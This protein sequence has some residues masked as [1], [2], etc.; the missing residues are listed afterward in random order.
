MTETVFDEAKTTSTSEEP[1]QEENLQAEPVNEEKPNAS[2]EALMKKAS[3][4]DEHIAT[5]TKENAEM[6]EQ[7]AKQKGVEEVLERLQAHQESSQDE[8]SPSIDLSEIKKLVESTFQEK[9][10]SQ[11]KQKNLEESMKFL[12][13]TYGDKAADVL[14]K[15]AAETGEDIDALRDLASTRP[16]L[17]RAVLKS[18]QEQATS[19]DSVEPSSS[20]NTEALGY[21]SADEKRAAELRDMFKSNRKQYYTKKHQDEVFRLAK[22]GIKVI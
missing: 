3:H 2:L 8:T 11:F 6:R 7:L 13:D 9:A 15:R 1:K 10:E 17:F 18:S 22:K 5:L 4:A 20:V 19:Q 12:K 16:Q 21:T 14:R